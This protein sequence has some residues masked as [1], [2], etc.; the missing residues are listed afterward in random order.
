MTLP[1][2]AGLIGVGGAA[3][4][5]AG[6]LSSGSSWRQWG[7]LASFSISGIG[8]LSTAYERWRDRRRQG[9]GTA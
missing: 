3:L 1:L 8:S 9:D 6:L 7:L 2:I 4:A 5:I